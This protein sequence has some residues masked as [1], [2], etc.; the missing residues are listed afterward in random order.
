MGVFNWQKS[1]LRDGYWIKV[2]TVTIP[3]P[4]GFV[5]KLGDTV[6]ANGNKWTVK[7]IIEGGVGQPLYYELE[8]S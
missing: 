3:L 6:T 5:P 7:S 8:I 1:V 2:S 4:D